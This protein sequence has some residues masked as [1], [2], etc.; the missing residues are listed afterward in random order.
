MCDDPESSNVWNCLRGFLVVGEVSE[1][2]NE[3]SKREVVLRWRGGTLSVEA[4]LC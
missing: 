4:T 1:R 3:F 2:K